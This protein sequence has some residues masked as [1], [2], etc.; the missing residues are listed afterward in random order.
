M[1]AYVLDGRNTV[2]PVLSAELAREQAN[3]R[4][5]LND[6]QRNAIE[7][8]LNSTDRIHGLQ[9]LAGSGKTTTLQT[10]R[11]GAELSG[12]K[13]AELPRRLGSR[14]EALDLVPTQLRAL[15]DGLERRRLS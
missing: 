14:G 8:V 2:A 11:E 10:I 12:Y 5:F 3:T 13:V 6:S 1:L 4:S 15:A 7:Q 9:G